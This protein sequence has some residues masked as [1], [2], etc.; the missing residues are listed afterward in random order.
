M[1]TRLVNAN[2]LNC[3]KNI[4]NI[5]EIPA[6]PPVATITPNIMALNKKM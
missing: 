4:S 6:K 1:T 3:G 2:T 5:M